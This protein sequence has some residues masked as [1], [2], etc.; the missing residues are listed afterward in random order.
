VKQFLSFLSVA[1]ALVL[2]SSCGSGPE[3]SLK[4]EPAPDQFKVRM[5][6][7]KGDVVVL[8][9]RDWSPIGVDHFYEL[10]KL[11]FFDN[12]AFFRALPNFV[13]QWGINGDPAVN[14]KWDQITIKDDPPKMPNKP[15]TLVFAKSQNPNSRSTQLFINLRDNSDALD[16]QGFTPLGEIIQ[17]MD[18]VLKINTEYGEM[19]PGGPGPSPA[20][21]ADIGNPYLEEHFPRLD[22]IKKAQVLP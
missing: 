15:G 19:S 16:P 4:M 12:N 21:I 9:H 8:L 17:G 6:T 1:A 5:Q 18:N 7:T 11:R 10:V 20:A 3:K 22:Y 2:A 14:R 13:V